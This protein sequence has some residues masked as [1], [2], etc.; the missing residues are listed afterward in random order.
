VTFVIYSATP[1]NQFDITQP[2]ENITQI[3]QDIARIKRQ[4]KENITMTSN[5]DEKK[6]QQQ[7]SEEQEQAKPKIIKDAPEFIFLTETYK[8]KEEVKPEENKRGQLSE[9]NKSQEKDN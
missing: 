2:S 7:P 1:E 4:D 8:T 9:E 3:K 5:E 6:T